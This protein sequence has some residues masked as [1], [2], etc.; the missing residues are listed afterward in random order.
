[1]KLSIAV[2]PTSL[3]VVA[4]EKFDDF[5]GFSDHWAERLAPP[6]ARLNHWDHAA[7]SWESPPLEAPITLRPALQCLVSDGFGARDAAAEQAMLARICAGLGI[8]S[9]GLHQA[10][11]TELPPA[12]FT[13]D[14]HACLSA[15][16]QAL[17]SWDIFGQAH[18]EHFVLRGPVGRVTDWILLSLAI[19]FTLS[20]VPV[21]VPLHGHISDP[22]GVLTERMPDYLNA[23]PDEAR[24]IAGLRARP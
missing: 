16:Q 5:R 8:T 10:V 2:G 3:D 20:A 14:T 23:R 7:Q 24:R 17:R 18:F 21:S 4:F 19:D 12:R 15:E 6:G 22:T 11:E 9:A 13:I 1:M